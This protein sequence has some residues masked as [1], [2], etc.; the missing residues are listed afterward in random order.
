M[1]PMLHDQIAA[2]LADAPRFA[3]LGMSMRDERTRERE[4][5][6][7]ADYL[8]ERLEQPGTAA[9]ADVDQLRLPL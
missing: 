4:R 3:I 1:F 9:A 5:G 7:L 8:A 6:A 2:A